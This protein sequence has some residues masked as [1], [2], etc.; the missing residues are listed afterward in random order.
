M[1]RDAQLADVLAEF[2]RTM[3]TDFPIDA[4]LDHL[5]ERIVHVLPITAAGV[6]LM[7]KTSNPRFIAASNDSALALEQLQSSLGNGPCV[8]AYES[9]EAVVVTDIANDERFPDFSP[10][11][12]DVGL[13][14]AFAFPLRHNDGRLGALDLFRDE[15]GPLDEWAMSAAQTLADVAA[16]YLVNAQGRQEGIESTEV[17]RNSTLH[18]PLTGLPNRVMLQERLGHAAERA[19]R[20]HATAGV[21]FADLDDFKQVNDTYGHTVGD[22]LLVAVAHRLTGVLRPGDTI[23]RVSGDEFVVLCEDLATIEAVEIVAA[24]VTGAFDEPFTVS[25]DGSGLIHILITASVG[26]AFAGHAD[27]I[28]MQL[29]RDADVAMYQVK[30]KGGA[31]YQV[32]DVTEAAEAAD[33]VELQRDLRKAV[34]AQELGLAYQPIVRVSDGEVIGAEALLRWVHPTRGPIPAMAT[35]AMAEE[36]DLI[37]DIGRWVLERSVRDRSRWLHDCPGQP[38]DLAINVSPRE[39]MSAGFATSVARAL[40]LAQMEPAALILEMTETIFLEDTERAMSVLADLK[41]IGVRLALDDFGTGYSSLGYLRQFPVDIVKIDRSFIADIGVEPT[42]GAIVAA[43]TDLAHVLGLRVTVEGV[44]T[45]HQLDE[46]ATFGCDSAQGYLYARPMSPDDF[47]RALAAEPSRT[48][49]LPAV[50][51]AD[52]P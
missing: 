45:P 40:E 42:G 44:E 21:L 41:T 23:A 50:D 28:G 36:R 17:L 20:T 32:V 39:V 4:I 38:L 13:V 26:I 8:M 7:T 22:A 16:A 25:A 29:I 46:V 11:A 5:V 47:A 14:G 35:V 15:A 6:T 19:R 27:A 10:R 9:G 43:V 52:H 24:R 30:R 18:D 3:V 2:A 12:A 48:L 31:T 49:R 51:V 37:Q 33:H 34:S 1:D